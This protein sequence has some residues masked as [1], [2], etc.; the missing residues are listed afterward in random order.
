MPAMFPR[1]SVTVDQPVPTTAVGLTTPEGKL[2]LEFE[3]D[4]APIIGRVVLSGDD[5]R[6]IM[7]PVGDSMAEALKRLFVA[8]AASA[9]LAKGDTKGSA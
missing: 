2:R 9:A 7:G 8:M 6:S 5:P 1:T 3:L 4:L